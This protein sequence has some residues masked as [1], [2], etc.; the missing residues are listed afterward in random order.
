MLPFT[1]RPGREDTGDVAKDDMPKST[2]VPPPSMVKR[3]VPPPMNPP[4]AANTHSSLVNVMR[5]PQDSVGDDDLTGIVPSRSFTGPGLPIPAAGRPAVAPSSRARPSVRPPPSMRPPPSSLNSS[6]LDRGALANQADED[7]EDDDDGRT[8]V[9]GAPKIVKRSNVKQRDV[10]SPAAVIKATLES[11]RANDER[12]RE[13][14]REREAGLIMAGP[15]RDLLEDSADFGTDYTEQQQQPPQRSAFAR[16]AQPQVFS[17]PQNQ[18]HY[19]IE[20]PPSHRPPQ[21]IEGP[22]SYPP[23]SNNAFGV[24]APSSRPHVHYGTAV[25]PQSNVGVRQVGPGYQ[26]PPPAPGSVPGVAPSVPAHF[27]TPA[28]APTYGVDPPGTAV[29]SGHRVAGRPAT[30]WAVALLACGLFV[31]VASVAV[32]QSSDTVADTTASFVDPSRAPTKA[33]AAQQPPAAQQAPTPV[34]VDQNGTPQQ[35]AA[36]TPPPQVIG[37]SAPAAV[38]AAPPSLAP[39]NVPVT[40]PGGALI[41]GFAA[42]PVT[43]AP[44]PAAPAAA[45]PPTQAPAAA[46][47]AAAPTPTPKAASGG[48]KWRP[49]PPPPKKAASE[50]EPPPKKTATAKPA[51][52]NAPA[53]DE[54]KKALEALQKAQLESA[55]SFGKE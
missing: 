15:P 54:T 25:L 31:G 35:V 29:T 30:S 3:S 36:P 32:M 20:G 4:G 21:S 52:N 9:R 55:S 53:D 34:P 46:P 41:T 42:V 12:E 2:S 19:L 16:T 51:K 23:S 43:T 13:R 49:P 17:S 33:Q 28:A 45:A 27:M 47:V 48:W 39:V 37:A 24:G 1:K 5:P 22:P 11:S 50:D 8:V 10:L 26:Q 18:P 44:T 14:E 6:S 40:P 7:A 38:S